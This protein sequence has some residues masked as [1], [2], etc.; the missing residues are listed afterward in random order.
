[1]PGSDT[2]RVA[3][4]PMAYTF[5]I[6]YPGKET[7]ALYIQDLTE[8]NETER[9]LSSSPADYV[10]Q[11]PK[12]VGGSCVMTPAAYEVLNRLAAVKTAAP[13]SLG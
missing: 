2:R 3:T 9:A 1:M 10:I 12:W 5:T 13:V 8:A 4:K 7:E 6:K 11:A